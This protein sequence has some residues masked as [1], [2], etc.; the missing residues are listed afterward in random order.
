MPQLG[1]WLA[2]IRLL[3]YKLKEMCLTRDV[4]TLS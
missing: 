3:S 2:G 1:R 4:A